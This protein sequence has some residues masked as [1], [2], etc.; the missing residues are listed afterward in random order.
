MWDID[1]DGFNSFQGAGILDFATLSLDE[2]TMKVV[3]FADDREEN[4]E[5]LIGL[6]ST[7][8]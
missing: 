1:G 7:S 4:N 6:T 8:S 5:E 3:L 2:P